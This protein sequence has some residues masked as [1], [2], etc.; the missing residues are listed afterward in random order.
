MLTMVFALFGLSLPHD[1]TMP[2][3]RSTFVPKP[4]R[5]ARLAEHDWETRV[6]CN[7]TLSE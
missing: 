4:Q 7:L 5:R 2:F 3:T 1:H 6:L